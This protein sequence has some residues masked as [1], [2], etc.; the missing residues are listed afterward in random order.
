[1]VFGTGR[2]GALRIA[3]EALIGSIRQRYL[4]VH[5]SEVASTLVYG[6]PAFFAS[7]DLLNAQGV[8]VR[9]LGLAV[10]IGDDN[11]LISVFVSQPADPAEILPVVDHVVASFEAT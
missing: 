4:D 8:R 9:F 7:G 3:T 5:T 11:R 2:P 6:R 1:M 10:R